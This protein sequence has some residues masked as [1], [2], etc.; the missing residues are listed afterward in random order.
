MTPKP[1][2]QRM[3]ESGRR[4]CES[5]AAELMQAEIDEWRKQAQCA[6]QPAKAEG[7]PVGVAVPMPGT[8]GGFTMCSFKASDMPEGAKIYAA[9]PPA[10]VAAPAAQGIITA[11]EFIEKRAEEYLQE[12]ADYEPETGALAFEFG[13]AGREYHSGLVELAEEIRALVAAPSPKGQP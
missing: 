7:E 4:E 8:K 11:A 5:L 10:P 12:H 3:S 2:E 13:E 9:P 1:W 6:A